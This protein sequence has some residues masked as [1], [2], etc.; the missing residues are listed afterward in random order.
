L[1]LQLPLKTGALLLEVAPFFFI[2]QDDNYAIKTV[3][4]RF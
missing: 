2:R 1:L 3:I 4:E